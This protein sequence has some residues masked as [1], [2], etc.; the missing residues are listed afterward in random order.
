MSR[1]SRQR[2][3][4]Q[5][6]PLCHSFVRF[7]AGLAGSLV[8]TIAIHAAELTPV[9]PGTGGLTKLTPASIDR[10]LGLGQVLGGAISNAVL[11]TKARP[12]H[13]QP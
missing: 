9:P 11:R 13:A 12:L 5:I 2:P 3:W 8:K 4:K 1:R 10:V 7:V 6:S